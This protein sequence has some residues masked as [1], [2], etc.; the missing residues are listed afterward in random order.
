MED[1]ARKGKGDERGRIWRGG[2]KAYQA[3]EGAQGRVVGVGGRRGG[4]QGG[5]GGGWVGD[6]VRHGCWLLGGS[7]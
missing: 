3:V 6:G 1:E 4:G 7:I 2:Q 5:E